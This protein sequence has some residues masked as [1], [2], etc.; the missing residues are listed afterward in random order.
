MTWEVVQVIP[1]LILTFS[2]VWSLLT[3]VT[4]TMC[5]VQI[6]QRPPHLWL[7]GGRELHGGG[8][9]EGIKIDFNDLQFLSPTTGISGIASRIVK[10]L[11]K[12]DW[13]LLNILLRGGF[14]GLCVITNATR[15]CLPLFLYCNAAARGCSLAL[16]SAL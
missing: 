10:L 9:F 3:E 8:K 11:C 5:L 16:L 7:P 15:F 4:S 6:M 2:P 13:W 12:T 1:C 14:R